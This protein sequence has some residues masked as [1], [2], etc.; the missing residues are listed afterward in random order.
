MYLGLSHN[1]L[2]AKYYAADPRRNPWRDGERREKRARVNYS[3]R[4]LNGLASAAPTVSI[5]PTK[6]VPD[7]QKTLT[8]LVQTGLSVYQAERL[9]KENLERIRNGQAPLTEAQMRAL[10]PTAN[11]AVTLPPAIQYGA[12]AGGA[13]LI[14][15]LAT[16]KGRR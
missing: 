12:L 9:R 10:A 6:P 13:A 4:G 2:R 16:R 3:E 7:W 5:D 11:V 14:Y 15:L 1:F 8:Q